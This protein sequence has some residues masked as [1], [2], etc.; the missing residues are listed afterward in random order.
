V[1]ISRVAGEVARTGQ[2]ALLL[3][4]FAFI[5]LFIGLLNLLPLPPFD[6]GHLAVLLI[7]KIRGRGVDMRK[8][9]PVSAVVLVF[10]VMFTMATVFLDLTKPLQVS[11]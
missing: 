4:M 1:G 11:P 7:E 9:V 6:G 5:N 8:M 10:F 2:V 3:Q